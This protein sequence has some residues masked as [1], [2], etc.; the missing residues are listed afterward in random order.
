IQESI[1]I[2]KHVAVLHF[3]QAT[4]TGIT[5]PRLDFVKK[6]K[7]RYGNALVIVVDAA[8]V[9]CTDYSIK[10]YLDQGFCVFVTGSK[11]FA[12]VSF[13]GAAFIPEKEAISVHD[14][15]VYV[16][17]SFSDYI[18]RD[19]IDEKL[20]SFRAKFA[21]WKN[22]GG[23]LRWETALCE[24]EK[25][26]AI[27]QSLRN[28]IISDWV[29]GVE[30]LIKKSESVRLFKQ[31]GKFLD[32]PV[33]GSMMAGC[34]SIIPICFD[35]QKNDTKGEALKYIHKLLFDDISMDFSAS[36]SQEERALAKEK[37]LIGQP[38]ILS[39]GD[40]SVGV[41]RIALSAPM[42]IAMAGNDEMYTDAVKKRV[43][44]ELAYDK[45]IVDKLTLI[46]K[47][48]SALK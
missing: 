10:S 44:K 38:V 8:Q 45:K 36:V 14:E 15:N 2:K 29:Q 33:D 3:V 42:V 28:S 43:E 41:L 9:R 32:D 4:K 19:D 16:P 48:F 47:Y 25:F 6:M 34:S 12:G 1:E 39:D 17:T 13:C 11:F 40:C 21:S 7:A 22:Y 31:C 46:S 35:G 30:E 18:T 5:V 27:P 37:F 20:V 23:L 26:Y 24:M